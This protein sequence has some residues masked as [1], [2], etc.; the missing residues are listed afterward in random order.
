MA[1]S[2][3][4]RKSMEIGALG[5]AIMTLVGC[6]GHSSKLNTEFKDGVRTQVFHP[7]AGSR[8]LTEIIQECDGNTLVQNTTDVDFHLK[9][10]KK[11][12]DVSTHFSS[13]D[14]SPWCE[15]GIVTVDDLKRPLIST[16]VTTTGEH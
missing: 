11:V 13:I 14:N 16:N 5:T 10:G 1:M 12:Y 2:E 9:D 6:G 7:V 3:F 8:V 4:Y 15:D